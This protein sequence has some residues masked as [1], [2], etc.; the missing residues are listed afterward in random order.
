MDN[1]TYFREINKNIHPSAEEVT[2]LHQYV[3][4]NL[5]DIKTV[6][7]EF[8][9]R[10]IDEIGQKFG[11][12]VDLKALQQLSFQ[13]ADGVRY[14]E[15]KL[16]AVYSGGKTSCR[17]LGFELENPH[18]DYCVNYFLES[19]KLDIKFYDL[20]IDNYIKPA[21]PKGAFVASPF[22][23]GLSRQ[24]NRFDYY[25]CHPNMEE[26]SNFFN[27]PAPTVSE[28]SAIDGNNEVLKVFGLAYDPQ[29]LRPIKL[30]RYYYPQDPYLNYILFDEE[31]AHV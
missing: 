10:F 25:F 15:D 9:I 24:K 20:D 8:L 12:A 21:M 29:T 19:K 17:E 3:D 11:V 4:E 27:L 7:K 6:P 31:L 5:F 23:L 14:F 18:D 26:V 30:K 16:M 28:L 1:L 2:I 22:G 13:A